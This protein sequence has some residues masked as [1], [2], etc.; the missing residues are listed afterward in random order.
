MRII[1]LTINKTENMGKIRFFI[2]SFFMLFNGFSLLAQAKTTKPVKQVQKTVKVPKKAPVV[3]QKVPVRPVVKPLPVKPLPVKPLPKRNLLT[4]KIKISRKQINFYAKKKIITTRS[5]LAKVTPIK[6]APKGRFVIKHDLANKVKHKAASVKL[7]RVTKAKKNRF[8]I[9]KK[10]KKEE[11]LMAKK[12]KKPKKA[13]RFEIEKV[14]KVVAPVVVE[15]VTEPKVAEVKPVEKAPAE[16]NAETTEEPVNTL[17]PE[18][19]RNQFEVGRRMFAKLDSTQ[20]DVDPSQALKVMEAAARGGNQEALWFLGSAYM[21]GTK[22]I[23][24]DTKTAKYWFQ[25]YKES[26]SARP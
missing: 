2:L 11:V 16:Q 12:E 9:K 18:E 6:P 5:P 20:T 23:L 24:K 21:S 17:S 26:V 19:A 25:K 15:T 10:S 7:A 8:V 13:P 22:Y 3:A 4:Q 14:E 1:V